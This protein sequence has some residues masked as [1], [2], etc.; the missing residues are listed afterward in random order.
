MANGLAVC[1]AGWSLASRT[2]LLN[3]YMAGDEGAG[4]DADRAAL[5]E[6]MS[7][8][9]VNVRLPDRRG[10][11]AAPAALTEPLVPSEPEAD[12]EALLARPGRYSHPNS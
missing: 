10:T 8:L 6:R 3:F 7:R 2:Y 11:P 5:A 12:E 9:S 1:A 4:A